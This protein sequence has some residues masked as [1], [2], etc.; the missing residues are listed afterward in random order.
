MKDKLVQWMA[1]RPSRRLAVRWSLMFVGAWLLES[2]L[3]VLLGRSGLVAQLLAPSA[4]ISLLF[5]LLGG[6]FLL[7]LRLCRVLV[8]PALVGGTWVLALWPGRRGSR[9][10]S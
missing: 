6:L 3:A 10:T 8:L 7:A 2:V 4:S 9:S 5:A 1:S